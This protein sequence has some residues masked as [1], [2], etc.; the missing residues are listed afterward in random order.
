MS[1]VTSVETAAASIEGAGV[2]STMG[3]GAACT[4][5]GSMREYGALIDTRTAMNHLAVT[6]GA[7]ATATFNKGES[8]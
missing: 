1:A 2:R 7:V 6:A 5:S 3:S 4:M 8:I